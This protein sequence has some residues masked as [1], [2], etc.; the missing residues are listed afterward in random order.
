MERLL[1]AKEAAEVLNISVYS[2]KSKLRDGIYKGVQIGNRWKMSESELSK[3]IGG[4]HE[5]TK[6]RQG[7]HRQA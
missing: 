5:R 1:S 2:L 7:I 6:E 3:I 4:D